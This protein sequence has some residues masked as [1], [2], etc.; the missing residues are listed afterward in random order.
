MAAHETGFDGKG[1]DGLAG[2]LRW[3][4]MVEPRSFSSLL[5]KLVPLQIVG[6]FDPNS[7][8]MTRDEVMAKLRERGLPFIPI[9]GISPE[10]VRGTVEEIKTV[11]GS[12]EDVSSPTRPS[13]FSGVA[14]PR[15]ED[16]G[17]PPE[18]ETTVN[19][20]DVETTV[21]PDDDGDD[22]PAGTGRVITL[23]RR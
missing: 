19:P 1:K 7:A 13:K 20:D 16:E 9:F 8:T 10:S 23:V 2:Y 22:G 14:P 17:K 15:G 21:N 6:S 4:S 12:V 5:G 11:T 18:R 3:L